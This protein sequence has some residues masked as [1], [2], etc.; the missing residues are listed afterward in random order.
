MEEEDLLGRDGC[1]GGG[2][3]TSEVRKDVVEEED[4]P[5]R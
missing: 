3:P 4:L 5:L 1:G 2:G